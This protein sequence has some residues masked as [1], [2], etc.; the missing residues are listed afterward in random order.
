MKPILVIVALWILVTALCAETFDPLAFRSSAPSFSLLN[1]NKMTMHHTMSFASGMVSTG[2]GFYASTY[3]NHIQ[4]DFN[5]K[6]KMNIDLNFVNGG[7][8]VHQKGLN[9]DSND[10]NNTKVLPDLRLQYNPT[11]NSVIRFEFRTSSP[12]SYYT[13]YPWQE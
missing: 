12:Y 4:Y 13:D 8:M 1:P 9:F 10:D 7:T 2:Q 6:L 3:T 11:E 5:P